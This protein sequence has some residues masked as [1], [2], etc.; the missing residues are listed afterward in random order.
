MPERSPLAG[1]SFLVLSLLLPGLLLVGEHFAGSLLAGAGW[2]KPSVA[3]VL[4]WCAQTAAALGV[5]LLR[6]SRGNAGLWSDSGHLA[7]RWGGAAL[8]CLL[9]IGGPLALLQSA[10]SLGHSLLLSGMA[11]LLLIGVWWQWPQWQRL[12]AYGGAA[13][14]PDTHPPVAA[15]ASWRGL[16]QVATPITAL[17]AGGLCLAWPEL[18][19]GPARLMAGAAYACLL[20][21]AHLLLQAGTEVAA[22]LAAATRQ[23]QLH[24]LPVVDMATHGAAA[25]SEFESADADAAIEIVFEDAPDLQPPLPAPIAAANPVATLFP[26]LAKSG[27][28]PAPAAAEISMLSRQLQQ[29]ARNGRVDRALALLASGAD[30][31][32]PADPTTRDRRSLAVLAA[33]LPDLRLLR[34]LIEHKVDVNALQDGINPLLAATRDSWHGRPEAVMTLLANGADPHITDTDGN[35]PLHHAA[36]SSDPGVAALLRDAGANLDALNHDGVS[37]LGSACAAGNW[38]LARFLLERGAHA[39]IGGGQPALLSAAASDEDD[40]AGVQLLLRHKARVN[41]CDAHGRS[42][43][44]EAA[45]ADHAE[46]CTALLDAG[47]EVNARAADGR[48]PLLDAVRNG[49]MHALEVLI[50]AGADVHACD[51]GGNTA[52]HLA[53]AAET[54]VTDLVADLRDL[55]LDPHAL[56]AHGRSSL[57]VAEATGRWNLVGLLDPRR[58][59]PV[60]LTDDGSATSDR[61]PLLLLREGL[62]ENAAPQ[63]LNALVAQLAPRDFDALLADDEVVAEPARLRWL[64][65]HGANPEARQPT[66]A[67]PVPARLQQGIAAIPV[68]QLLFAAGASPAGAGGLASFLAAC[69]SATPGHPGETFALELLER[70]ADPFAAGHTASAPL[71]HAVRL[72]WDGLLQ[73]LLQ[74]GVDPEVCDNRGMAALHHAATLGRQHALKLLVAHGAAPDRRAADGQTPLGIALASGQ[75]ALVDWLDWP[76]WPLPH[77]RLQASDLPAAAI[78]GDLPAVQRLLALGFAVDAVDAQ[79]CTALLRAAGSGHREL[80]SYLLTQAA[81]PDLAASTGATP[82]SA[83]VSKRQLAI[84]DLLLQAGCSTEHRLPGDVTV[85]M[86]AAALGLPE[87][88]S[89]LLQVGADLH[90][91]DAQGYTPLHCAAMYGFTERDRSR[92]M[93]LLDAL[94]LAGADAQA[95]ANNGATPLLLL[96]GARTEPGTPSNQDVLLAGV[97]RLL[98]EDARLDI[99]DARGLSPL[100]LAAMHGLQRV[101]QRLLHA[102][103]DPQLRDNAG[104][105]PREVAQLRGYVEIAA[106]LAPTATPTTGPLSMARFLKD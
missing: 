42:A 67:M 44:H 60:A 31:L 23:P 53:C 65:Q 19:T 99:C 88:V 76:N 34:A 74:L 81:N 27:S 85:L 80:V 10:P 38:R 50:A 51:A 62:L 15:R 89:R 101:A 47:A 40:A 36:R 43:L 22:P 14:H 3:G 37:P 54:P 95:R 75:R 92:L 70:G 102:G 71:L 49:A 55:G 90:A 33:V 77:R 32:A 106:Q 94:L 2:I 11:G 41:A 98:D 6:G 12:E 100:H 82:L 8:A 39:E 29:A 105:T 24:G 7:L 68:L 17:L 45:A 28:V 91:R 30:P 35:T 48:T 1:A 13:R 20:P 79:G 4:A 16:L 21:L 9:L 93:A 58:A 72:G 56:D 63:R 96:L 5:A 52:L 86:L 46:V 83:A 69:T 18:L 97:E 87:V 64:L 73:R 84:V 78:T 26:T 59:L 103:A 61:P 66:G 104:R 25:A 57:D